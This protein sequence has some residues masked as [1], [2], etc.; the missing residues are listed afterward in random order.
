MAMKLKH[1]RSGV[2]NVAPTQAQI[3]VGQ[4][5]INYADERLF[6][7]NAAGEVVIIASAD[8]VTRATSSVLKVNN[9][10]PDVNGNVTL[11]PTNI[12]TDGVAPLNASGKI[13]SQ[14]LP[15]S[16]IGSVVYIGT[17]NASTNNPTLPSATTVKGQYYVVTTAGTYNTLDFG[18]GDWVISNGVEW[19]KVDAADAV[20]S[21]AG[22]T[23][24]VVLAAADIA[25]GTFTAAR[26]G[27]ASGND[28]VLTTNGTGAPTWV[29]RA[30]VSGVTSVGIVPPSA[31]FT[32]ANSP[33]TT[34]GNITMTLV[35]QTNNMVFAGPAASGTAAPAFRLLVAADI[36]DL[37]ASKITSGTMDPAILGSGT[38]N[39]KILTTDGAG[40][41]A[42]V[43]RTSF[44]TG[45]V[46]SVGMTVPSTLLAV[47]GSPITTTGTL[48]LTL[49]T[50][51]ANLVFAGPAT[52]AAAA[53][54]F[55]ALVQEDIPTLDEG[56]F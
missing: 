32:V 42:W 55:R 33:I 11:D 10:G 12:G 23:G 3:D 53:P 31:L 48:A 47:T 8:A 43:D 9:I 46:S 37:A 16:L 49:P 40:A 21:V 39:N 5:A 15:E 35:N 25:S 45:S 52:G 17:W 18:V 22:K 4:I 50:R 1:L 29:A 38:G 26:L 30:T 41:P 34:S 14:Y 7:K 28:M 24:A 6:I 36:P 56:T 13:P 2:T 19:Q 51:A 44:G 27:A 20:T 54:A